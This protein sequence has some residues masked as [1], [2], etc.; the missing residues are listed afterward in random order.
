MQRGS[1]N[2]VGAAPAVRRES[3]RRRHALPERRPHCL[4]QA[5]SA[6]HPDHHHQR[7][8]W[9]AGGLRAVRVCRELVFMLWREIIGSEYMFVGMCVYVFRDCSIFICLRVRIGIRQ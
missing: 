8:E 6:L 9:L 2:R 1:R 4:A 5:S 3:R 7:G